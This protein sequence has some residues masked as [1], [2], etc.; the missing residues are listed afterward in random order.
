MLSLLFFKLV[1]SVGAL[2]LALT[3]CCL[4]L[5]NILFSTLIANATPALQIPFDDNQVLKL[6]YGWSYFLVMVTGI[7]CI[8]QAAV[9]IFMD[10]RF[11]RQL[12]KFFSTSVQDN[13]CPDETDIDES[14]E[15]AAVGS[16]SGHH[17]VQMGNSPTEPPASQ[18]SKRRFTS[19]SVRPSLRALRRLPSSDTTPT[20][21]YL[22]P[23]YVNI[24]LDENGMIK[25]ETPTSHRPLRRQPTANANLSVPLSTRK[26]SDV[27]EEQE[28]NQETVESSLQLE[29]QP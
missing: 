14:N 27:G 24:T 10:Y 19:P 3:G 26:L 18:L 25:A 1:L 23:G 20:T 12:A 7:L 21:N 2:F 5:S 22:R 11:P 17:V 6:Q 13:E 8:L 15:V 16:N 28:T 4:L 29:Q 9:V